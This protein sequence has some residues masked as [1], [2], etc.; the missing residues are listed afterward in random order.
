M[1]NRG[2]QSTENFTL[3]YTLAP[4]RRRGANLAP[5]MW[6]YFDSNRKFLS[7]IYLKETNEKMVN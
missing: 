1:S 3:P 7:K 4:Q 2:L 5:I 6:M